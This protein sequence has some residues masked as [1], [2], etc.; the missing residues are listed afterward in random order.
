MV[1]VINGL[2][3]HLHNIFFRIQ[4]LMWFDL[5]LKFPSA[6]ILKQHNFLV[7]FMKQ[8]LLV[9]LRQQNNFMYLG[10]KHGIH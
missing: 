9:K 5:V 7:R 10:V 6:T 8:N 2:S 4:L 3:F 1:I